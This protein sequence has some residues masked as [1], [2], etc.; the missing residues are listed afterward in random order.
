M[1]QPY[2]EQHCHYHSS[3]SAGAKHQPCIVFGAKKSVCLWVCSVQCAGVQKSACLRV[4]ACT[5]FVCMNVC[6]CVRLHGIHIKQFWRWLCFPGCHEYKRKHPSS[7]NTISQVVTVKLTLPSD[8]RHTERERDRGWRRE[9]YRNTDIDRRGCQ[10]SSDF[11]AHCYIFQL[12]PI[13][14]LGYYVLHCWI[15][16]KANHAD[17]FSLIQCMLTLFKLQFLWN[18]PN[19]CFALITEKDIRSLF[20]LCSMLNQ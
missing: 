12:H 16:L 7:W 14:N 1:H 9:R 18:R 5:M 13:L 20:E 8:C 17:W 4:R 19:I 2:W 6:V 3:S 10:P 11:L 15:P